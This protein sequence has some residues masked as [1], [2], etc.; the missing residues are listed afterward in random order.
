MCRRFDSAPD[1]TLAAHGSPWAACVLA[2]AF[3]VKR[4]ANPPPLPQALY[5]YLRSTMLL[6]IP[7]PSATT[8]VLTAALYL[9]AGF[10]AGLFTAYAL[11]ARRRSEPSR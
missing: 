6:H 9:I 2:S 5:S 1:H 8:D 11:I 3:P 4:K 10:A 7:P